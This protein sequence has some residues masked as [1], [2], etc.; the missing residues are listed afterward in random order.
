MKK[1]I[2][3]Y[4]MNYKKKN[5]TKKKLREK[6]N[7]NQKKKELLEERIVNKKMKIVVGHFRIISVVIEISMEAVNCSKATISQAL[8]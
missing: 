8:L 7:I 6:K 1:N 2:Y 4:I 5:I 3:Y